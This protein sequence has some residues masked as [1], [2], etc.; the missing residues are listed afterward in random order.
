MFRNHLLRVESM[1]QQKAFGGKNSKHDKSDK[2][3]RDIAHLQ[4]KISI[5][6]YNLRVG[7]IPK[8]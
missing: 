1:N 2:V 3:Y 5:F 6:L 7:D 8:Y 4:V